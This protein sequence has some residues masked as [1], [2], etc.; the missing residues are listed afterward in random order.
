MVPA[1]LPVTSA[2]RRAARPVGAARSTRL[3]WVSNTV[4]IENHGYVASECWCGSEFLEQLKAAYNAGIL[5]EWE[6]KYGKDPAT[7][8]ERA[9]L[10][11]SMPQGPPSPRSMWIEF[12]VESK[13]PI[14]FKQWENPDWDGPAQVVVEKITYYESLP[15]ELFEFEIPEGAKVIEE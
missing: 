5:T 4:H 6:V 9:Y 12:D 14:S 8:R 7:G 11:F 2:I 3:P 15:D 13:L 1:F 10:T